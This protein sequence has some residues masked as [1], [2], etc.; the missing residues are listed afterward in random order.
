MHDEQ[1][2]LAHKRKRRSTGVDCSRP[3]RDCPSDP[4]E[5]GTRWSKVGQGD[6]HFRRSEGESTS[7]RAKI[8]VL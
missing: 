2:I 5:S 3:T 8:G 7:C 1:E 6:E 4:V